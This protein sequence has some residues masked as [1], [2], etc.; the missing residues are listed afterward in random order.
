MIP[1]VND[2]YKY[3]LLYSA[4]SGCTSLRMLYLD[5]HHDE[6]SEAQRAQLDDYHNLHEVQP[7]V[8]GKDYSEYFTYTITRNPYLRIV[9]AYLDQYVYA[10]NS[11]MQRM[12]GEFPPASGLPDNFIEFLEYLSTVPE[13][14]RD[15][16][17]QSQSHFGFAGTI[18]TTKNRR[19][20][21][22]GQK[23][24]YAFG[25]QYY[26]DIGDFKKHT[27]RVFKRVFKRDKAKLAE[28]LA[29]L[30]NSVK[31]N[32]SFY[33]EEDYAD[34][35]LLSV[36]ELGELVF[37]PKPQDF[38]RN[39]RARELVQQIYAQDFKLFGYDPEAVPNRSASREIAAI[40]DDLDWQMYRRLNPDLTPDVFYNERLVMRHY[41]EFGRLEKPA[42]PYK[43]EAPAGFDW[44]RYLTLHDDLTA[45][46]IATEQAAIEHYLS[47]GIRENREI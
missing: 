41:L 9:S 15:E 30:E 13:G 10:K 38:Y 12:L 16:H 7:Y 5:V 29:H 8:D 23:P 40:P 36:A 27:K 4:K 34:A 19:Y 25:V 11:G 1:V 24:D 21:W 17:V 28:A 42:R 46:G 31:H 20:K 6:L 22:L 3:I 33:G 14:H 32:S 35:A 43:L 47:Y 37:A 39:T 45:A 2:K 18:V 26:G 44:Q